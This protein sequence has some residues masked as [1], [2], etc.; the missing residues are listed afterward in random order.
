EKLAFNTA[1]SQMMIFVKSFTGS[2]VRPLSVLVR[3]LHL[4]SPYA[5]HVSEE[6]MTRMQDR[7]GATRCGDSLAYGAWPEWD[8]TVLAKQEVELVVQVNGKLRDRIRLD[9]DAPREH[10]EKAAA[11]S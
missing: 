4:L 2:E 7:F 5:P 8:E 9:V 11:A 6:L 10:V 3:F 1:I